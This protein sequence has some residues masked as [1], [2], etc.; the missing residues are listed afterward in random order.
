MGRR[1]GADGQTVRGTVQDLSRD[2][3]TLLTGVL[4]Q[5]TGQVAVDV[6]TAPVCNIEPSSGLISDRKCR[7][8][9]GRVG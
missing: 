9:V 3:W 8:F 6:Y 2:A 1:A 7:Q 5:H 4:F